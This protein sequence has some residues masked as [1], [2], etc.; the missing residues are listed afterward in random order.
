MELLKILAEDG[1]LVGLVEKVIFI[2]VFKINIVISSSYSRKLYSVLAAIT[3][4]CFYS[5][6]IRSF[7]SRIK[8]ERHRKAHV[9]SVQISLVE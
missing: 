9:R 8:H 5:G 7:G 3:V 1:K 2:T 4:C 6:Y